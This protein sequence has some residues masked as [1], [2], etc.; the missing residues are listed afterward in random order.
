MAKNKK[1]VPVKKKQPAVKTKNAGKQNTSRVLKKE[2]VE[3]QPIR[4]VVEV[5]IRTESGGIIKQIAGSQGFEA[6]SFALEANRPANFT[7][8]FSLTNVTVL[9]FIVGEKDFEMPAEAGEFFTPVRDLRVPPHIQITVVAVENLPGG[10]GT[11]SMTYNGKPVFTP[12]AE[13]INIA[14]GL[15]FTKDVTLPE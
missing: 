6:R 8:S 3:M 1:Q 11:L 7:Y 15:G 5:V 2:P 10:S 4:I 9:H 14:A 13:L 12:A